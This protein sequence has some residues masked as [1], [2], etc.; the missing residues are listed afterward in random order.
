M[1]FKTG[2]LLHYDGTSWADVAGGLSFPNGLALSNDGRQ[3]FLAETRAKKLV[4]Y[5]RNPETDVIE[6]VRD[7]S[8]KTFPDNLSIDPFGGVFGWGGAATAV[9]ACL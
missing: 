8:I 7:I 1:G 6:H 3:L 2:Q 4:E 9:P 5:Q